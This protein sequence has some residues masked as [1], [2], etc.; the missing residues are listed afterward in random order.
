MDHAFSIILILVILSILATGGIFA[1]QYFGMPEEKM[2]EEVSE[3]ETADWKIYESPLMGYAI[4]YPSS[5]EV[6]EDIDVNIG[7]TYRPDADRLYFIEE[8][9]MNLDIESWTKMGEGF[10]TLQDWIA[11]RKDDLTN[12]TRGIEEVLEY[13]EENIIL[14]GVSAKKITAINI[15]K[16]WKWQYVE[17]FTQRRER[18]YEIRVEISFDKK[19]VALPI[20][21]KMLSTFRFIES[22]EI[23]GSYIEVL[24]PNRG[25]KWIEGKEYE[26]KWET[27][28]IDL[29]DINLL[30]CQT[31]DCKNFIRYKIAGFVEAEQRNYN[32]KVPTGSNFSQIFPNVIQTSF[33][34]NCAIIEIMTPPA[35]DLES[36]RDLS[37]A[38]FTITIKDET[39]D[40]K[41]YENT[42]GNYQLSYPSNW[43]IDEQFLKKDVT[44]TKSE[45]GKRYTSMEIYFSQTLLEG[46]TLEEYAEEVKNDLVGHPNVQNFKE[47]KTLL[48]GVQAIKFTYNEVLRTVYNE[49]FLIQKNEGVYDIKIEFA[50]EK[51]TY[52][53]I[54]NQ[55]LSTFRFLE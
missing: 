49:R 38:C 20:F 18:M 30:S 31:S 25:E 5:W 43:R 3:D 35:G 11:R 22:E 19:N 1:W 50:R 26:I 47:E 13:K 51:E 45:E 12:P 23:A 10:I 17:I 27:K 39:A 53:P 29:A 28:G 4:Q 36:V 42:I 40:W 48:G 2:K 46:K 7:G 16:S 52:F 54:I 6:G 14:D 21:E 37:D 33:T 8:E 55:M 24:S 34:G 32:W 41:V 9:D 44:F 15:V